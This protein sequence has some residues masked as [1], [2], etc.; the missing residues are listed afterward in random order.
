MNEDAWHMTWWQWALVTG[1]CCVA[2]AAV[3]GCTR[4]SMAPYARVRSYAMSSE[5]GRVTFTQLYRE[6]FKER[7]DWWENPPL[8]VPFGDTQGRPDEKR[9]PQKKEDS[10]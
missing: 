7:P 3:L 4:V 10:T 2:L 5:S 6:E 8:E 9:V 1:L